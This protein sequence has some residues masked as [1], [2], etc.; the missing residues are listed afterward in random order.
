MGFHLDQVDNSGEVALLADRDLHDQR[1][2]P[3]PFLDRVDRHKEI[4]PDPVHLVHE[5]DPGHVVPV[6][7]AP[8]RLGLRLYSG[9]PVEY[10]H[11]TV[12]HP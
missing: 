1:D 8:Y 3:Q 12:Q 10:G 9:H 6:R 5:T 7:L 2:G 11:R 4:G